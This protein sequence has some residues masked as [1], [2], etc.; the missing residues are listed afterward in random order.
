MKRS[1]YGTDPFSIPKLRYDSVTVST[2]AKS[3]SA[4]LQAVFRYVIKLLCSTWPNST[5]KLTLECVSATLADLLSQRTR[6]DP[7]ALG[8]DLR[9][10]SMVSHLP[11]FAINWL[12]FCASNVRSNGSHHPHF[13][14]VTCGS[15][16]QYVRTTSRK[17]EGWRMDIRFNMMR[18]TGALN[19]TCQT[20]LLCYPQAEFAC[21]RIENL[22]RPTRV[23]D[24]ISK[25]LRNRLRVRA[26]DKLDYLNRREFRDFLV[27]QPLV[28]VN[29]FPVFCRNLFLACR[30]TACPAHA[31]AMVAASLAAGTILCNCDLHNIVPSWLMAPDCPLVDAN[32]FTQTNATRSIIQ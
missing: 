24:E 4:C 12:R 9:C 30:P 28:C 21:R 27:S 6:N 5:V 18:L 23:A 16:A 17:S 1:P 13:S 8:R 20:S 2:N 26:N 31:S 19:F 7:S 22:D 3:A 15:S 25:R 14:G 32:N 29:L 11:L 10:Q